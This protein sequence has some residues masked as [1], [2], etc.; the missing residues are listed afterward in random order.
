VDVHT[1]RGAEQ[2]RRRVE[3][4]AVAVADL[5]RR[6]RARVGQQADDVLRQ[7]MEAEVP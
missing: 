7:D 2:A 6:E 5:Q 4:P 1:D 3:E